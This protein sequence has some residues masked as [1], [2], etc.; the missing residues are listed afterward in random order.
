MEEFKLIFIPKDEDFILIID[1]TIK[2]HKSGLKK[3]M[4]KKLQDLEEN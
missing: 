2:E 1:N 3:S 4:R